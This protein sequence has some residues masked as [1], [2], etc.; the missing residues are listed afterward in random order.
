MALKQILHVDAYKY[1]SPTAVRY[2]NKEG[3]SIVIRK[4]TIFYDFTLNVKG[5]YVSLSPTGPFYK[6]SNEAL[7]TLASRSKEHMLDV[8]GSTMEPS[9]KSVRT[10]DNVIEYQ[11]L[12]LKK[13]G[14]ILSKLRSFL[15]HSLP[16]G[17]VVTEI[18]T[19]NNSRIEGQLGVM[20]Q[21]K[22]ISCKLAF[23]LRANPF[24]S[25]S[26]WVPRKLKIIDEKQ[27]PLWS[28]RMCKQIPEIQ[29][30]LCKSL[31]LKKNKVTKGKSIVSLPAKNFDGTIYQ[32]S[33][34][35]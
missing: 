19:V 1:V 2:T 11:L 16:E 34:K 15:E 35:I 3:E 24:F 25:Y 33:T 4:G 8:H 13:R 6:L 18:N 5:N 31:K 30:V 26:L 20:Y 23:Y 29:E 22:G 14:I 12:L 21:K 17:S 28:R 9:D 32:W 7:S 27:L 10:F